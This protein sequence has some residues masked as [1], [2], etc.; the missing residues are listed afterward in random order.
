MRG[1]V[2]RRTL[3]NLDVERVLDKAGYKKRQILEL[4]K[5]NYTHL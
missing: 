4:D 5:T 2:I 1:V 3:V